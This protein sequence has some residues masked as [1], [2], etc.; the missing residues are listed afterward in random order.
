VHT[1]RP[2]QVAVASRPSTRRHIPTPNSFLPVA[3]PLKEAAD[4]PL[5]RS[6]EKKLSSF[7][8]SSSRLL[9][10]NRGPAAPSTN[11]VLLTQ[12][13]PSRFHS[14][15]ALR[16]WL[17]A[18][19]NAGNIQFV[20]PAPDDADNY[21]KRTKEEPMIA[22]LLT[23]SHADAALKVVAAFR[24]FKKE[25][26]QQELAGETK[27]QAHLVPIRPKVPLPPAVVDP[28]TEKVLGHKLLAALSFSTRSYSSLNFSTPSSA[29]PLIL[30]A[31]AAFDVHF[32]SGALR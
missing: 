27:F 21:S 16:E 30:P 4:T 13:L 28:T 24:H 20:P 31:R 2:R 8:G 32:C 1:L 5:R 10:S 14:R 9:L 6:L 18:C 19:G 29:H 23:L 15:Q 11:T 22:A 26:K 25:L 7:I 12:H 17:V 3:V